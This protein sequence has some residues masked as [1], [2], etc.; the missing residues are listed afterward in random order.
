MLGSRRKNQVGLLVSAPSS[1]AW[2]SPT[3][4]VLALPQVDLPAL[5]LKAQVLPWHPSA[6]L[7]RCDQLEA[8]AFVCVCVCVYVYS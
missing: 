2:Y 8:F 1:W 5:A 6:S 3:W 7:G 4:R